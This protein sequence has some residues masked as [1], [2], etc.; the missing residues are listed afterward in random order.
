MSQRSGQVR[1]TG[2][3]NDSSLEARADREG[4]MAAAGQQ[5]YTGP[6]TRALS[7]VA[8]SPFM[9]GAMQAKRESDVDRAERIGSGMLFDSDRDR[10]Y[11]DYIRNTSLQ[12]SREEG[13]RRGLTGKDLEKFIDDRDNDDDYVKSFAR[14]PKTLVSKKDQDWFF[15]KMNT[16]DA[17]FFRKITKRKN[18]AMDRLLKHRQAMGSD[19]GP[20]ARQLDYEAS[21]SVPAQEMKLYEY[22]TQQA[23][24]NKALMQV[25][26]ENPDN[27]EITKKYQRAL[28]II[29][30]QDENSA[31]LAPIRKELINPSM[32]YTFLK[33]A[34][35]DK[36]ANKVLSDA[37]KKYRNRHGGMPSKKRPGLIEE[38]RILNEEPRINLLD[39]GSLEDS[40]IRKPDPLPGKGKISDKRPKAGRGV[41]LT[42]YPFDDRML[43]NRNP[44]K[45]ESGQVD[46]LVRANVDE[47]V[48][49]GAGMLAYEN[50]KV[51]HQEEK[52][53]KLK[54]KY[55]A[56]GMD[57]DDANYQARLEAGKEIKE[58]N[59]YNSEETEWYDL[60]MKIATVDEYDELMRRVTAEK[61]SS[62]HTVGSWK[63]II[64]ASLRRPWICMHITPTMASSTRS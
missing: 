5:V 39:S 43:K 11:K 20:N 14:K 44:A 16:A 23:M 37:G 29:V 28:K 60:A 56:R 62:L 46:Q 13:I 22:M 54:Q 3:L 42:N 6:V 50:E 47:M 4:A 17:G 8:P 27:E 24:G 30:P 48:R 19:K 55:M 9:A 1:G 18:A 49:I 33:T 38:P 7:G 61:K 15:N 52:S 26:R 2:F 21:F 59:Y 36:S 31:D 10:D 35:W 58:K 32:R 63:R 41:G 34:G 57:E 51:F 40:L 64:P 12:A 45:P 53:P 25:G